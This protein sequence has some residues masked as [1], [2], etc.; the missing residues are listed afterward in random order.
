M[1]LFLHRTAKKRVEYALVLVAVGIMSAGMIMPVLPELIETMV[2]SNARAGLVNGWMVALFAGFQFLC[3]P[4]IGSL[5]DKFG[6]RPLIV[7]SALGAMLDFT[8][9]ALAPNYWWIAVGRIITGVT[10]SLHTVFAYVTD[11]TTP[12]QRARRFGFMGAMMTVGLIAGPLTGGLLS[13][14]I[15]PRAPFWGAAVLALA[16]FLY[17]LFALPESL[18]RDKRRD[19]S[20]R[21]A[22]PFGSLMLLRSHPE[23]LGLATVFFFLSF[24]EPLFQSVLVLYTTY[25][26]QWDMLEV[27]GMFAA[28]GVLNIIVQGLVVGRAVRWLGER[29]AMIVG[30]CSAAIAVVGMGLAPNGILFALCMLPYALVGLAMPTIQSMLTQRVSESEQGQLQG[31]NNVV[32]SVAGV[33]GPLAFGYVYSISI[34]TAPLIAIPGAVFFCAGVVLVLGAGAG[35]L[36]SRHAQRQGEGV[37][38]SLQ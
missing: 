34:G 24:V 22:N 11:I 38:V 17:V 25:R 35:V 2:H 36:A 9:V 12:Q 28:G 4:V 20:W 26:Y 33:A 6:R 13:H 31:A 1:N 14:F 21:R 30:L 23:L 8:I 15:S 7:I 37:A 18:D 19:F 3:S 29:R 10:G 5:S 32:A 16:T 27:V